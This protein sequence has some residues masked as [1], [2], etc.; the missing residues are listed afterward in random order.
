MQSD[1]LSVLN[2]KHVVSYTP[3]HAS[4]MTERIKKVLKTVAESGGALTS[5]D[6]NA[7]LGYFASIKN[8]EAADHIWQY[9]ALSGMPRDITNYNSYV[10]AKLVVGELDRALETIR[11]IRRAGLQPNSYTQASLIRLYGLLGDLEAAKRVFGFACSSTKL[12]VWAEKF[13]QFVKKHIGYWQDSLEDANLSGPTVHIYN[14]ML[15]VLGMNGMVEEMRALFEEMVVEREIKPTRKSF[16][17]MIKWHAKY[18]DMDSAEK[19]LE[20][21]PGCKVQPTPATFKL[22]I[23]PETATRDLNR[24][25][26]LAMEMTTK[27]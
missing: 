12:A 11:E 22:L 16:E 3:Y 14:E 9:A 5:R 17:V 10:N 15:D 7:L 13:M 25:G 8:S 1:I 6:L 18:W 20:M 27:Y 23:T 2:L 26:K 24:C 4:R 19:Y 21:M